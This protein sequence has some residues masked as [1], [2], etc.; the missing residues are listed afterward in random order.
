MGDEA[1]IIQLAEGIFIR[2]DVDNCTWADMGAYAV[3]IDALEQAHLEGEV[4]AAIRDTIGE[5]P[6][7]YVLNTHMHYD[8][9]ALHPALIRAGA[10][11]V[12]EESG[13]RNGD[14]GKDYVTFATSWEEGGPGRRVEMHAVGP[15][16]TPEDAVVFFPDDGLLCVGDLFGWGLIPMEPFRVAGEGTVLDV[17][18][19]LI[20]FGA[21]TVIPGHGPV[22][23]L[24]HLR[25]WV[26]YF[27]DMRAKIG[28]LK[29]SGMSADEIKAA[30]EPPDDMRDWWRFTEWK[31]EHNINEI[32]SAL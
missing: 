16:H 24:D 19:R 27:N 9:V 25:R 32:C 11:V 29:A 10:T 3:V 6:I 4:L 8:H 17:Y 28:E 22:A 21:E 15:C 13:Y 14:G 5:K 20:D 12:C 23:T 18:E 30:V 7:R 2:Q 31:H 26:A 1:R